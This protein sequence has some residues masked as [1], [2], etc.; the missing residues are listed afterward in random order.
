MTTIPTIS[1][2]YTNILS[3]LQAEFSVTTNPFGNAFL[4]ALA[5]VMSGCLWL[6]WLAVALLQNNLWVDTCDLPT[7]IRYGVIILGRNMF[8]AQPGIYTLTVTGTMSAVIPATTVYKSDD[9]SESPGMLYQIT[10]GAY[11]MPGTTGTI[12]VKALAGGN[13]SALQVGDTLTATAPIA[14]VSPDAVVGA[15]VTAPIDAE[16]EAAYRQAVINKIQLTPGSWSAVDYRLVGDNIDGIYQTYAYIDPANTNVVNVYLQG[17]IPGTPISGGIIANYA[18]AIAID[19]PIG[20][21]IINTVATPIDAIAIVITAGS[22]TPFTAAQQLLVK[23]A[24]INFVNNVHPFIPAC[25][26]VIQRN[27]VIASFNLNVVISQAV[28]GYGYSGVTFT[29]NGV[30]SSNYQCGLGG[31]GNVPYLSPLAISFI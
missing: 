5:G 10:G 9:D 3:N 25:D 7:L 18:A 2:L 14:V 31:I 28:P 17:E 22:F 30:G 24:L 29:V 23:T 13:A 20:T 1:Q 8:Q 27:D 4:I 19:R 12:T 21:F 16:T 6:L 15:I 26:I 11:T